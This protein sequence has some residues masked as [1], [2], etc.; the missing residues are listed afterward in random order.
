MFR[1]NNMVTVFDFGSKNVKVITGQVK[2]KFIKIDDYQ[3][4]PTPEGSIV[5]GKIINKGDITEL[6]TKIKMK[7][8]NI[9]ILLASSEIVLRTFELPV[10]DNDELKQAVKFEMSVLLPESVDEFIVDS[11]VLEVFTKKNEE[12]NEI[13]MCKVQ[14]VAV[15]REIINDY[16]TCFAKAGYK[17]NVVDI[18]PNCVTKLFCNENNY[19]VA[20]NEKNI[21]NDNFAIIDFGH[22]KT[23]ITFIE[24]RDVFLHR[25]LKLGGKD[26][27]KV[28]SN[29]LDLDFKRAEKWKHEN[30][31]YFLNKSKM[32]EIESMLYD[33][34]T[35][36]YND[37]TLE[38][39]QVIEFF[40]SMSKLKK[41]DHIF[42]I[43]GGSLIP[44]IDDY[45][46]K[47]TNINTEIIK[48]LNN[49]E[50]KN[51]TSENNVAI[52]ANTIGAIVRRG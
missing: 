3:I 15:L 25:N 38:I 22:E 6:L 28:I 12:D 2:D 48:K 43:G 19:I 8:K 42:I 16:I 46:K 30:D 29:I 52:L 39:Y 20:D 44:Q 40:I 49:I 7:S 37:I 36:I 9:R 31:F 24:N 23:S 5:D 17:V 18:Q 27:T 1:S 33:E 14:G 41:I 13:S 21:D 45:I 32:N 11:N 47:Y 51:N 4:I 50:I 35:K 26:I 34:I 10:M